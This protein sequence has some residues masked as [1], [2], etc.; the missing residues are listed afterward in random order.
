MRVPP[1]LSLCRRPACGRA[2]P[3]RHARGEDGG[4]LRGLCPAVSLPA[5]AGLPELHGL[6]AGA[7]PPEEAFPG[8]RAAREA[9][10]G[11]GWGC[12]ERGPAVQAPL[13]LPWGR[14]AA[15]LVSAAPPRRIT[16]SP[17]QTWRGRPPGLRSV[18]RGGAVSPFGEVSGSRTPTKSLNRP[19]RHPT[20]AESPRLSPGQVWRRTLCH[21]QAV[22]RTPAGAALAPGVAD[23]PPRS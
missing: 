2:Q 7:P 14:G 8:K 6:C 20:L 12:G 19:P 18:A 11:A 4:S 13:S 15:R 22:R 9:A 3:Q 21:L 16:G 10:V 1:L 23:E 17:S 5:A